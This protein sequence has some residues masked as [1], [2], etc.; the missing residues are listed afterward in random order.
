VQTDGTSFTI[1]K[2]A[3][4]TIGTVVLPTIP[5]NQIP[6][7]YMQITT[8]SG[9]IFDASTDDLAVSGTS[10]G[11]A[12]IAWTDAPYVSLIGNLRGAQRTATA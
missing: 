11:I 6:V 5:D 7:S 12:T 10:T 8:G 4:Q 1:T 2:A 3:D 9:G